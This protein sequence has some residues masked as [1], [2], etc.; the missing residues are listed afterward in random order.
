MMVLIL[1]C[2]VLIPIP[3]QHQRIFIS[4]FLRLYFPAKKVARVIQQ[5][6]LEF[7][8]WAIGEIHIFHSYHPFCYS[9]N[10]D[11]MLFQARSR[12]EISD[13]TACRQRKLLKSTPHTHICIPIAY[14]GEVLAN[15]I[16]NVEF[17]T[18]MENV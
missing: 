11:Y 17:F 3:I 18:H 12:G 1:R 13:S 6:V 8:V 2:W 9:I 7:S 5:S 14:F 16:L 15:I 10:H 4:L